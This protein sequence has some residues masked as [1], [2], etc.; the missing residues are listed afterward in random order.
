VKPSQKI[1]QHQQKIQELAQ[2]FGIKNLRIFGSVA[3][4]EDTENSDLDL[5]VEASPTTTLFDILGLQI[6]LEELLNIKVDVVTDNSL[7]PKFKDEVL[8]YAIAI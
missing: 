5:L 8:R 7:P 3:K 6:E 1:R 4:G 2:Q